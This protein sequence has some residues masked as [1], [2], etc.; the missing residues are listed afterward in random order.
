MLMESRVKFR[1]TQNIFPELRGKTPFKSILRNSCSRW[2][3]VLKG[4]VCSFGE[5][6]LIRGE[7]SSL[8]GFDMLKK[9]QLI[10][11]TDLKRATQY[12]FTL[13]YFYATFLASNRVLWTV[14]SSENSLLIQIWKK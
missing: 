12:C 8:A 4:A 10:K 1:G 7:R 14:F 2:G 11:Q 6:I 13:L 3:L 9:S 5:E